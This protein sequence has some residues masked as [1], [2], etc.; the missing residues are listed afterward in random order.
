M[1][2]IVDFGALNHSERGAEV[3]VVVDIDGGL[4]GKLFYTP[5]RPT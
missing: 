5:A 2:E 3:P 1:Y 4:K